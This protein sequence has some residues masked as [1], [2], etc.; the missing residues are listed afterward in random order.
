LIATFGCS[1]YITEKSE[2]GDVPTRL[3]LLEKDFAA[4]IGIKM[5]SPNEEEEDL[6]TQKGK[7]ITLHISRSERGSEFQINISEEE[8]LAVHLE[9]GQPIKF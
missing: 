1:T 3:V 2:S 9:V 6:A 8:H 7:L 5:T 4:L